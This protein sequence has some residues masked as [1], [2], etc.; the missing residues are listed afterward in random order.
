MSAGLSRTTWYLLAAALFAAACVL[1]FVGQPLPSE[2]RGEA[3][4]PQT[5]QAYEEPAATPVVAQKPEEAAPEQGVIMTR[6]V[7][8]DPGE[9]PIIPALPLE[10]G[11]LPWERRL[12]EITTNDKIS[13]SEKARAIFE[14]LPSM[15][16]QGRETAAEQAARLVSDEDYR[17]AQSVLLNPTTYPPALAALWTDMMERPDEITLPTLLL[18]ARNPAHP[19][20]PAAREN[21]EFLLG[22][23]MG[24]NWIGWETAIREHLAKK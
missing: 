21:L 12:R 4:I 22:R 14:M 5:P 19:Y 10:K 20:A 18:V 24:T 2:R 11:E 16:V 3:A 13:N 8:G 9:P 23:E 6:E 7:P 17:I 1:Y 15:P